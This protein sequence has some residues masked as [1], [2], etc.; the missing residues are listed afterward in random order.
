MA[1]TAGTGTARNGNGAERRRAQARPAGTITETEHVSS[2]TWFLF[3]EQESCSCSAL[4]LF[5]LCSDKLDLG[6]KFPDK[7]CKFFAL[8]T[9]NKGNKCEHG[10]HLNKEQLKEKR[11]PLEKAAKE[12][13]VPKE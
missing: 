9:C 11:K 12:N 2:G 7:L 13:K 3:R 5:R 6:T 10:E 4:F 8:G 1:G